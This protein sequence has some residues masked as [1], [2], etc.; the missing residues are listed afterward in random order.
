MF[1][2]NFLIMAVVMAVVYILLPTPSSE[3]KTPEKAGA[4]DF[5]FPTNNNARSIPILY[6]SVWMHGNTLE[7]C[8][9]RAYGIYT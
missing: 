3:N 8:C 7:T 1:F 2:I 9:M 6:G 5:S 4:D